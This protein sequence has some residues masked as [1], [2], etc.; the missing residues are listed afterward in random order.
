MARILLCDDSNLLLK[1][2]EKRMTDMGQE[3]V[4]KAKDGEECVR[5]YHE[6]K[7]D[8]LLLDVTMPNKDG[9]EALIE[10]LGKDPKANIIMISALMDDAVHADCV[11]NGAKA[12]L[13]KADLNSQEK[14]E[15]NV[16]TVLKPFLRVS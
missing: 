3:V 8:L 7:P 11:A 5:M 13:N 4:G 2:L 10:I 14:F 9:R 12:F 1:I 6:L 16:M 15:A